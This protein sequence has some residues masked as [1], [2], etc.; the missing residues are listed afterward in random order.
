MK[1][2]SLLILAVSVLFL[3]ACSSGSSPKK[4]VEKYLS[5]I[6]AGNYNKALETFYT[7]GED[8]PKEQMDALAAKMQTSF[9]EQ[10]GLASYEI[11]S[12]EM[13]EP[14]EGQPEKAIVKVKVVYGD[15][16]DQELDM[17]VVKTKDGWMIDMTAK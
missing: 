5:E 16:K 2:L 15:G 14:E 8:V 9:E 6:K 17:P 4:P 1:K 3:A 10:N 13:Q 12:E 11:I 7:G